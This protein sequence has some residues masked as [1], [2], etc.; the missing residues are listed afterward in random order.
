MR[1][2]RNAAKCAKK[3]R[4]NVKELVTMQ[5]PSVLKRPWF[6][7]V[8]CSNGFSPLDKALE[9]SRKKHQFDVQKKSTRAAAEIPFSSGSKLFEELTGHPVDQIQIV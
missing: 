9:I 7:C 4:G 2:A 1:P 5:G 6:Y 3:R 8:D